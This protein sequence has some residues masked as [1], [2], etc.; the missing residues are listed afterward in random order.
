MGT[1]LHSNDD[2]G[3]LSHAGHGGHGLSLEAVVTLGHVGQGL[4]LESIV[5]LGHAGHTGGTILDLRI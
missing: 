2:S 1:F 3:H 4:S 5:T